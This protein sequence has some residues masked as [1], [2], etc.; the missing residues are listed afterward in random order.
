MLC[1]KFGKKWCLSFCSYAN[2]KVNSNKFGIDIFRDFNQNFLDGIRS[3]FFWL[4]FEDKSG[5]FE[6]LVSGF[7]RVGVVLS[8]IRV[9]VWRLRVRFWR[10]GAFWEWSV[11]WCSRRC[12]ERNET[13]GQLYHK[14][15]GFFKNL[16]K[17][18]QSLFSQF[19][20]TVCFSFVNSGCLIEVS[21]FDQ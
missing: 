6:D 17:P 19:S 13:R 20:Y 5:V 8:K 1:S 14:T 16:L 9:F 21:Y 2:Q 11:V 7:G 15:L 3:C 4:I 12:S 10:L 18:F